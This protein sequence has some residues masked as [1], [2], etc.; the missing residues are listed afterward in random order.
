MRPTIAFPFDQVQ[1]TACQ[2]EPGG[3][4]LLAVVDLSGTP[5]FV[6]TLYGVF[7][8]MGIWRTGGTFL[9][10]PAALDVTLQSFAIKSGVPTPSNEQLILVR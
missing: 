5:M 8:A 7:D 4:V 1:M 3:T 10:T 9:R 6:P 2:G